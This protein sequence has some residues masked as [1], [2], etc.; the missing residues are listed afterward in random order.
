M[1]DSLQRGSRAKRARIY[2]PRSLLS[3]RS[4]QGNIPEQV[5][6]IVTYAV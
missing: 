5:K 1:S 4:I 6:T 2:R 3:A